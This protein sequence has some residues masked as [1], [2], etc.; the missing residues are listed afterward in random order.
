M[1]I[2]PFCTE[3]YV[4]IMLYY[5]WPSIERKEVEL[6]DDKLFSGAGNVYLRNIVYGT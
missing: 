2:T 3:K 5:C 1:E 6:E 4:L